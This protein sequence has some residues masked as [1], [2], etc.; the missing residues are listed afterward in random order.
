MDTAGKQLATKIQTVQQDMDVTVVVHVKRF[1]VNA[2]KTVTVVNALIKNVSKRSVTA[3]IDMTIVIQHP[4]T[5]REL[6]ILLQWNTMEEKL[7]A[8]HNGGGDHRADKFSAVFTIIALI[9]H[10]IAFGC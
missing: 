9:L 1:W 3:R 7:K 2:K 10:E 4:V 5:H 6:L 8:N